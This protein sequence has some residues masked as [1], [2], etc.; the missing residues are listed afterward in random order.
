M[1]PIH[2][3]VPNPTEYTH[4]MYIQDSKFSSSYHDKT[5]CGK[6]PHTHTDFQKSFK[7]HTYQKKRASRNKKRVNTLSERLWMIRD[8]IS[9]F[10]DKMM[11]NEPHKVNRQ[12]SRDDVGWW[13]GERRECSFVLEFSCWIWQLIWVPETKRSVVQH[14]IHC[15]GCQK[16]QLQSSVERRRACLL[17]DFF[18]FVFSFLLFFSF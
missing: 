14:P 7:T 5:L 4:T 17:L 10:K 9:Q 12:G 16:S 1:E 6:R 11:M 2:S 13:W 18:V 15:I 3:C 8:R